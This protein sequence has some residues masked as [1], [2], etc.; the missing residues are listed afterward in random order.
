ICAGTAGGI[1]RRQRIGAREPRICPEDKKHEGDNQRENNPARAAEETLD[2]VATFA[3]GSALTWGNTTARP[4]PGSTTA[5]SAD[6]PGA[7][8]LPLNWCSVVCVITFRRHL[9][10]RAP[11]RGASN[12]TRG[13]CCVRAD[14]E[15]G[16]LRR[17]TVG[18]RID[19]MERPCRRLLAAL[20]LRGARRAGR[21]LR[22]TPGS[23]TLGPRTLWTSTFAAHDG[24]T[25][26]V[27]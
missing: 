11:L 12:G 3:S 20:R 9:L 8:K 4:T 7:L 24:A 18:G 22:T 27:S 21:L 19:R 2:G 10:A 16:G 5:G 26:A 17:L 14:I 13:A 6:L 25:V 15:A 23:G 1:A